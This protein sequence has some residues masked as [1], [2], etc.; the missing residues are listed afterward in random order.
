MKFVVSVQ[1]E[2]KRCFILLH[3]GGFGLVQ[4]TTAAREHLRIIKGSLLFVFEGKT[5]IYLIF[6]LYILPTT[7]TYLF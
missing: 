1:G 7:G 5:L 3:R 4:D 2:G 6:L